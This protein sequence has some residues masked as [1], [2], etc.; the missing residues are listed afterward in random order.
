MR[1]SGK[2]DFA[3]DCD[4]DGGG[5]G[6]RSKCWVARSNEMGMAAN[7][8][9]TGQLEIAVRGLARRTPAQST[10]ADR[11][12][13]NQFGT[14]PSSPELSSRS[15]LEHQ[16]SESGRSKRPNNRV[17]LPAWARNGDAFP[18]EVNFEHFYTKSPRSPTATTSLGSR[19]NVLASCETWMSPS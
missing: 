12:D 7:Q 1:K 5:S 16:N 3:N 14:A 10:F 13:W 9:R 19:M 6:D 17:R 8:K 18:V 11:T 2:A 4:L 15:R